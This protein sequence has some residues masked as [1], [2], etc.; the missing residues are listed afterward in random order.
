MQALPKPLALFACAEDFGCQAVEA[1][2]VMGIKVPQ[3]VA[4]LGVDNDE[5]LCELSQPAMSSIYQHSALV[6]FE[7]A[8]VLHLLMNGPA[9]F[10]GNIINNQNVIITRQSTDVFAVKDEQIT[11]AI[12]YINTHAPKANNIY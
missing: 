3:E 12:M 5:S 7:A 9:S 2:K 8:R 4:V 1:C 6:G 10:I 11:K